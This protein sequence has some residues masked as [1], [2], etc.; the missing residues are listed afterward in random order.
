VSVLVLAATPGNDQDNRE[1]FTAIFEE[2]H[3][4]VLAYALRRSDTRANAEDAV[5]ETFLI[6][7]RRLAAVP[8]EPLPWLLATARKVIA[9]QHRSV[10][11]RRAAAPTVDLDQVD[12][13]DPTTPMAE[14]ITSRVALA[15]AFAALKQVDREVLT[16][17]A[18]DGLDT[19]AAAVV[20]GCSA[21]VFS[22]RLHR[23]R[24]RLTKELERRE[25]G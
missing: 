18:W 24:T 7:W 3:A 13:V 12:P 25:S 9:N 5:S 10:K 15:E 20:M 16:L 17:I 19:Q 11:R 8:G 14:R 2:T 4:R 21:S 22:L 6:A 23:A 1:R